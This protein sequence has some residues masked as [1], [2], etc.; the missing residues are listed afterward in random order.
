MMFATKNALY[1]A[2]AFIAISF[3]FDFKSVPIIGKL[4]LLDRPF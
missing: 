3:L 1:V 2:G 4:D